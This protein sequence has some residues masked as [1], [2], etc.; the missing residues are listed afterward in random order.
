VL[1][2]VLQL[3]VDHLIDIMFP[4]ILPQ[5]VKSV[6]RQTGQEQS[7]MHFAITF[8]LQRK[9]QSRACIELSNEFYVDVG[10]QCALCAQHIQPADLRR[11]WL[12]APTQGMSLFQLAG[13]WQVM[14]KS[15][16]CLYVTA[17]MSK[18]HKCVQ[19]M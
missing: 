9:L 18:R 4:C 12:R 15:N 14:V 19:Q 7:E 1:S 13:M 6:L 16:S 2:T 17:Q 3:L 11:S 10:I 8:I 5:D